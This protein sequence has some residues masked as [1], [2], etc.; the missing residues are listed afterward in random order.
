MTHRLSSDFFRRPVHE[1]ARDFLGRHLVREVD[2]GKQKSPIVCRVVEVEVYTGSKD[3]ASHARV[4]EP[5]ERT[6][7]MFG[8]PGTLYIY[9][10]Y[11]MWDCLNVTVRPEN[12]P[13][14]ILIRAA[15]PL[16][17]I[18]TMSR[19]RDISLPSNQRGDWPTSKLKNLLSG[20]GKLCQ[21][22]DITPRLNRSHHDSA[23]LWLGPGDRPAD[24]RPDNLSIEATPRV[25]LNPET[26]G[27][28]VE[29]PWRY[30]DADSDFLSR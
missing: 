25:G 22:L 17:G 13:A 30:V 15:E 28:A 9:R 21:A 7:P 6:E 8:A 27:E 14:A 26:V 20:P 11:G 29:W 18:P 5:T 19:R 1:V 16:R 3:P 10:I 4:G 23:P 24:A 12:E 2:D